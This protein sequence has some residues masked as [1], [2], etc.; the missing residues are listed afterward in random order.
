MGTAAFIM[1]ARH[2]MNHWLG[3]ALIGYGIFMV[4]TMIGYHL[5]ASPEMEGAERVISM[6][7]LGG[8]F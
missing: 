4:P 2:D 6:P 7:L 3:E 8:A 5:G 1:F